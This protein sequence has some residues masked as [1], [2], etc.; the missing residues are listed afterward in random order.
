M[1]P[2]EI[3]IKLKTHLKESRYMHSLCVADT[4]K[5]LAGIYGI[6]SHKA[7]I[8]GL[9]HDCAKCYSN[10][11]LAAKIKLYNIN[12]DDTSLSSPQLWHSF[13]GAFEARVEYGI[14]DEEIFD[15]IY[16]H[17]IG[18]EAMEPL[19]AIIYLADAIEPTRSY[20]GV[21]EIREA[22]EKSLEK[23]I[24]LYTKGTIDFVAS[25]GNALHPNALKVR[26]YYS[27]L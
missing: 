27:C 7:Y 22:A 21:D 24:Y 16:Y 19:T 23:A 9:V 20:P 1:T 3:K 4:A 13:V 11:E 12:L 14:R 10:E 26:D 18:K 5:K 8:A 17:T 6:D 2:E 15:A 25:K